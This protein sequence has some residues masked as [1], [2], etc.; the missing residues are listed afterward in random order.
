MLIH[1]YRRKEAVSV[2]LGD[3]TID[4]KPDADRKGAV[5]AEVA[6]EADAEQLLNIS[7]AYRPFDAAPTAKK[8]IL[9]GDAYE[10]TVDL[11][12]MDEAALTEFAKV[13]DFN[14]H[15]TWRGD[16]EKIRQKIYAR[17]AE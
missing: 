10:E 8:Y 13:N 1:A 3:I 5:V 17:F 14:I 12:A 11:G 15:H 6:D 2:D 9:K 16:A 4:F 7:E